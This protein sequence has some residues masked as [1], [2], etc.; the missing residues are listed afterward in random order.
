MITK[1]IRHELRLVLAN[2]KS[3]YTFATIFAV[4]AV[5]FNWLM[6]LYLQDQLLDSE[7]IVGVT[8]AVVHPFYAW[9][10]LCSL[11][12]IPNITAQ[13]I[14][15]EKTHGTLINYYFSQVTAAQLFWAKLLSLSVLLAAI[16]LSITL[17]PLTITLSASLDLGQLFAS[18]IG[19]YLMLLAAISFGLC[20]SAFMKHTLRASIIILC[21]LGL[22][23]MLEWAA[24]LSTFHALYLQQFALL[25][26]LKSFLSGLITPGYVMY[27][28]L[29]ILACTTIGSWRVEAGKY[30][31]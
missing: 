20:L 31:D 18:V 9:F 17:I 30:Y 23:I 29:V 24:Q 21:G 3:W 16:L 25:K 28:I 10:G 15:G 22:F 8:E 27:Y 26:P 12:V 2:P 13:Y 11:I 19:V 4:F 14:C 6:N 7:Q 5:I 1:L